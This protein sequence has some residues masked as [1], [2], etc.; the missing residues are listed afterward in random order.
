MVLDKGYTSDNNLLS[1]TL[2]QVGDLGKQLGKSVVEEAK[3]T[4]KVAG[5]QV[6]DFEKIPEQEKGE[7][8]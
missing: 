2:G 5:S 4:T 7:A 8:L 1:K 3:K 6:A